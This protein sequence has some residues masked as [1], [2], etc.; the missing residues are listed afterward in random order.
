[1][2]GSDQGVSDITNCVIRELAPEL[3]NDYVTFF[4]HDAF[5]D[6]PSWAACYCYFNQ[7]PHQFRNWDERTAAE[8]RQAVSHLIGAGEMQGYLAYV[9][10]K[11]IG[12][13]NAGAREQMTTYP[14]RTWPTGHEL[15]QLS[16]L[17]SPRLIEVEE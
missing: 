5:G 10:G 1:M 4:D 16:V 14:R 6:N 3:V 2:S 9:E 11:V 8:N 7:A 15:A 12:W 17:W 13:C